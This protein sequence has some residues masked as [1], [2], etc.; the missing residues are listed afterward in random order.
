M[1]LA[2]NRP[3]RSERIRGKNG[4]GCRD[5]NTSSI[6]GTMSQSMIEERNVTNKIIMESEK[7]KRKLS[8][9]PPNE[10][11]INTVIDDHPRSRSYSNSSNLSDDSKSNHEYDMYMDIDAL[12]TTPSI[13]RKSSASEMAAAVWLKSNS[14]PWVTAVDQENNEYYINIK[15]NEQQYWRPFTTNQ[16]NE[17][18]EEINNLSGKINELQTKIQDLTTRNDEISKFLIK[19]EVGSCTIM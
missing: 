14:S 19:K 9:I 1:E 6:T 7:E 2:Q 11:I 8:L 5:V 15:T 16:Q 4:I 12:S 3:R 13:K 18:M 10:C 17:A